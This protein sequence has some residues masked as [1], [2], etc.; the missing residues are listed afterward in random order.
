VAVY[1]SWGPG[2][3]DPRFN[4]DEIN[5]P[6]LIPPA[7]GL[8]GVA[9]E[10]YTGDGPI[11]YWNAYVAITQMGG[12]GDFEDPRLGIDIDSQPDLVTSR[13]PALRDYQLSLEAPPA[14]PGTFD[15]AA[16]ARGESV[17]TAFCAS[18]HV[19]PLYTDSLP[20]SE[21]LHDPTET[22]MDP[23]TA[24]RSAT[25]KYRTTPL[26]GLWQHPP[27]FHDG[28]ADTLEAVVDHYAGVFGFT[29]VGTQRSD[30]VAF[31]KSL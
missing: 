22:G 25:G 14:P 2:F 30:L 4:Q 1:T 16:A 8:A 6:V 23:T 26:R 3:Y 11:S 28:S 21:V 27:Y 10:T 18:C 13:L 5:H 7:Y 17:F 19:P 20:G 31:L 15:P 24:E 12:L 29:L 9:K